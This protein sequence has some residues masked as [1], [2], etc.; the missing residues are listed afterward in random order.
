MC[1]CVCVCVCVLLLLLLLLVV[2]VVV[3]FFTAHEKTV[4]RFL[5]NLD[6]FVRQRAGDHNILV[7]TTVMHYGKTKMAKVAHK[8]GM[9]TLPASEH[10]VW[11]PGGRLLT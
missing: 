9:S 10:G 3:V 7:T 4:Y 6:L 8:H 11:D 1:V 5:S 2:V